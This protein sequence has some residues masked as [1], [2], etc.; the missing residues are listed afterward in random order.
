MNFKWVLSPYSTKKR[1]GVGSSLRHLTHEMY[2]SNAKT[3]A[4]HPTQPIFHLK[5]G[6]RWV[7]NAK[8]STQKKWNVHGRRKKLASPNARDTNMLVFLALGDAKLLSF[9]L[10]DA[11]VPDARYFAFWWNIGFKLHFTRNTSQYTNIHSEQ[12]HW[13]CFVRG[14]TCHFNHNVMWWSLGFMVGSPCTMWVSRN[15]HV[16]CSCCSFPIMSLLGDPKTSQKGEK[17]CAH[18]EV[19]V[20]WIKSCAHEYGCTNATRFGS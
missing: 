5:T 6:L 16:A 11:K 9:A 7:P 18:T 1:V 12:R 14:E 20:Y 19:L 2:M 10:G 13:F 17:S 8:K 3:D 4:R 15:G